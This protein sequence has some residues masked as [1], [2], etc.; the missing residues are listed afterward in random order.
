MFK[1]ILIANRGEIALRILRACRELEIETVAIYSEADK[2]ALHARLADEA[3]CVGPSQSARSYL[4]IPNIISAAVLSDVD[5][6]HPGYGYLSEQARFADICETHGIKFIG[7]SVRCIEQM[8][9]KSVAKDAMRRA[10]VPVIPGSERAVSDEAEALRIAEEIGYPIMLKA[11]AGGGGK[12]MRVVHDSGSLVRA[13]QAAKAEAGAA[14][15]DDRVY[16]ERLITSP[17]HI[18]IQLLADEHGHV[19]HLG[20]RECSIQRRHQ[21]VIEEA[22]APGI[23]PDLRR[24][25]GEAAVRGAKAVGYAN[26]GTMEFLLDADGSFYFME[27]NTRIQ[28][29]HP[30]TEMVT[31]VDIVKEQIRIAAGERLAL[32]QDDITWDGHAI[33]CR[34]NAEDPE[35]GFRPSPGRITFYHPPGGLGVRVDSSAY[36]GGV[37]SPYYDSMIAKLIC[38]APDREQAIQR[39][40]AALDELTIEGIRVNIPLHQSILASDRFRRAELA[41]DFL[42]R[43][44]ED[45]EA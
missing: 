34:I 42:D 29:E 39:M 18:E 19:I 12:G 45:L 37:V 6:I 38:H 5:A 21:K 7:P 4:N 8:G 22:P 33:E 10:G 24:R 28:V 16:L 14:F 11:A 26:A 23:D 43:H 44:M 35:Q 1:R 20:E 30:V 17:R 25:M 31:G 40:Q 15:G 32:N 36:T 3:I 41:T 2:E 27:M 13:L 9:D